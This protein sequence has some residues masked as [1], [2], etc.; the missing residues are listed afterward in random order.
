MKCDRTSLPGHIM[1]CQLSP[2]RFSSLLDTLIFLLQDTVA[3]LYSVCIFQSYLMYNSHPWLWWTS[4]TYNTHDHVSTNNDN[5]HDTSKY[6]FQWLKIVNNQVLWNYSFY[7]GLFV[8]YLYNI[9]TL[10]G[11]CGLY[12]FLIIY[13]ILEIDNFIVLLIKIY[14]I[15]ECTAMD[16]PKP[17]FEFQTSHF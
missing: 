7:K 16:Y 17:M 11:I 5:K 10:S 12:L 1:V 13:C 8:I 9:N 3:T 2:G 15:K 6:T 14:S 4:D